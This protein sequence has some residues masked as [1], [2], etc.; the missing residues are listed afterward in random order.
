MNTLPV[1][2]ITTAILA[3]T[4]DAANGVV[5]CILTV[6]HVVVNVSADGTVIFIATVCCFPSPK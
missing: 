1:W 6:R 3:S 2:G 4:V 5:A